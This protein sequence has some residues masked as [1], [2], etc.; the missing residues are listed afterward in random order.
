MTRRTSVL[1]ATLLVASA[2][3]MSGCDKINQA[4]VQPALEEAAAGMTGKDLAAVGIAYQYYH[5]AHRQGPPGWDE[6][7]AFAEGQPDLDADAIRKVRD[8]GYQMQWNVEF[9]TVTAGLSNTVLAEN[10]AGGPKL[11]MDGSVQQ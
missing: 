3:G 8:A 2:L 4:V 5:D 7:I 11:M 9:R 6:F 10:P 1:A